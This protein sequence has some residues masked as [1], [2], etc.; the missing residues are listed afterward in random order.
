MWSS[1]RVIRFFFGGDTGYHPEL[2]KEVG[3]RFNVDVAILPIAPGG[4]QGIGGRIHVNA[5]GAI[6][7]LNDVGARFMVPMHYNTISYGSDQNPSLPLEN[8]RQ[9]AEEAGVQDRIIKLKTGEQR[10]LLR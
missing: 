6:Q 1:T 8:L 5:R 3:R 7:I 9:A 4:S 10:V 2:F